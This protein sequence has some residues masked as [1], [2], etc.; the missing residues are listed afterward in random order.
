MTR[1][2]TASAIASDI[3]LLVEMGYKRDATPPDQEDCIFYGKGKYTAIVFKT[4]NEEQF[5]D[6]GIFKRCDFDA[7]GNPI[8]KEYASPLPF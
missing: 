4:T 7:D 8:P 2:R 6:K 1:D 3:N 5:E